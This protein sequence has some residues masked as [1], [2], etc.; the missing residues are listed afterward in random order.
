[1]VVP[2]IGLL[3]AAGAVFVGR[4]LRAT[5]PVAHATVIDT[6]AAGTVERSY[7]GVL[8]N[9]QTTAHLHFPSGWRL[10]ETGGYKGRVRNSRVEWGRRRATRWGRNLANPDGPGSSRKTAEYAQL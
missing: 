3:F 9:S 1:M 10:V 2:A 8:S 4:D 6:G 7:V 5:R